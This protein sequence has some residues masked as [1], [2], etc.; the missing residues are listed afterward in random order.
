MLI[1]ELNKT[2]NIKK[3]QKGN[4]VKYIQTC[5]KAAGYDLGKFGPKKDGID[6]SWGSVTDKAFRAFQKDHKLKVDGIAGKDSLYELMFYFYPHFR[7]TEFRC[8]C[9]KYC[10]GYPVRVD[11]NLLVLLEAIREDIGNKPININSALRCN[12]H[13]KNVGGSPGSQHK[14]G[15]A[16]DIRSS[17]GVTKVWQTANKLNTKGGVGRYKTFTH[18]DTRGKKTRFDYR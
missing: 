11:E 14:L 15:K 9:N 16:A 12:Q 17:V 7:K 1:T 5:L 3:G 13:N 2:G 8:K 6:S 10:N 4:K 18:I